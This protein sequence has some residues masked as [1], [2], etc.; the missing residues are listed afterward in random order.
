MSQLFEKLADVGANLRGIGVG[1]L[2]LQFCDDLAES[3]LTVAV[4]EH[5]PACPLQLDRAFG[6][7][8]YA[9][10]LRATPA[11]PSGETR[12]AGILWRSHAS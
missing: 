8:D 2:G 4:L 9:V 12:L 6:E 11:A 10:L 1:E 5:L 3:A 7:E